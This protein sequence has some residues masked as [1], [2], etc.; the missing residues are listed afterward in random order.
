MLLPQSGISMTANSGGRF[1][2][3]GPMWSRTF[4]LPLCELI[5]RLHGLTLGRTEAFQLADSD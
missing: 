5:K 3:P 1:N 4:F 2:H